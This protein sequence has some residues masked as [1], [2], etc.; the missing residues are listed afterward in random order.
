[1]GDK[2]YGPDDR[3]FAR[4]ADDELTPDDAAVLELPRHA[5]HASRLALSHPITGARLVIEAPL[6]PDMAQFW[7]ALVPR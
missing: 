2:L 4:A 5:L 7:D 3:I 6:P 1:V